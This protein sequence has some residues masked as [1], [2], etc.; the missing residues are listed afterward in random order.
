MMRAGLIGLL[1]LVLAGYVV[2]ASEGRPGVIEGVVINGTDGK[3]VRGAVLT[4]DG[5]LLKAAAGRSGEFRFTGLSTGKY[6]LRVQSKNYFPMEHA[7]VLSPGELHAA[8]VIELKPYVFQDTMVV[9]PAPAPIINQQPEVSA[10]AVE[11]EEIEKLAGGLKDVNRVL[12]TMPGVVS[13]SDFSS[14][15]Y[16]RGGSFIETMSILNNC[17]LMNPYHMGGFTTIFNTSMIDDVEFSAGGFSV[18]YGNAMSGVVDVSYR[19]GN[20]MRFEGAVDISMIDSMMRLEGPLG[21]PETSYLIAARRTYYDLVVNA[22]DTEDLTA[23]PYFGDVFTRLTHQVRPGHKLS[24]DLTYYADSLRLSEVDELSRGVDE[25]GG[26]VFYKNNNTIG[27]LNYTGILS[28]SWLLRSTLSYSYLDVASEITGSDPMSITGDSSLWQWTSEALFSGFEGH[29]L[30]AGILAARFEIFL[31]TMLVDFRFDT[32][33]AHK[34]GYENLPELDLDFPREDSLY[35]GAYLQDR[36]ELFPERLIAQVGVR[37]DYWNRNDETTVSPRLQLTWNPNH[38]ASVKLAWGLYRQLPMDLIKIN[39]DWGN[40]DLESET[41]V[42]YIAGTE[43]RVSANTMLRIET[44]YKELDN[45]IANY[46]DPELALER[47]LAGEPWF[48]NSATGY[49]YGA[50]LFFQLKPARRFD[51]WV[52]YGYAVTKRHNPLHS[53]NSQWFYPTQDQ[54]HTLSFAANYSLTSKWYLS[55]KFTLNSGRPITKIN[56]WRVERSDPDDPDSALVWVVDAYGG[57]NGDRFPISHKLDMRIERTWRFDTWEWTLHLDLMNAY[58]AKNIYTYYYDEGEPP[59][60]EPKRETIYDEPIIPFL[61]LD[62][63]F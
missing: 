16:V 4:I 19:D 44:Y 22:M 34:P 12:Q 63:S 41:A 23:I 18:R 37:G 21:P 43:L 31:D 25:E 33:G 7:I 40:P 8:I 27:I 47:Y 1:V 59:G 38:D 58:D 46:D 14:L 62:I 60:T 55:A 61:G 30:S 45:L 56:S 48:D 49:S 2:S 52:T 9:V 13:D 29:D 51:G 57:L 50:E 6:L 20:M 32:P 26:R 17:M 53:I 24:L 3:P 10:I 42:H 15:M 39:E 5:T 54:R 11:P 35:C 36:W 28:E